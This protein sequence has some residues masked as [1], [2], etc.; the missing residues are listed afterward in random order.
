MLFISVTSDP[1]RSLS[2]LYMLQRDCGRF[3][4][5]SYSPGASYWMYS[6]PELVSLNCDPILAAYRPPSRT[7]LTAAGLDGSFQT[8]VVPAGGFWEFWSADESGQKPALRENTHTPVNALPESAG[9]SQKERAQVYGAHLRTRCWSCLLC[10]CFTEASLKNSFIPAA[11]FIKFIK[12]SAKCLD[13][14]EAPASR[15]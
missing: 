6:E 1:L 4:F 11:P 5:S 3:V 10:D 9:R 8:P 14:S 15:P 12:P 13:V 2:Y 7:S